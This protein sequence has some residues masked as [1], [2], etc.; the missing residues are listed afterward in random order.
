MIRPFP[1]DRALL[2]KVQQV[3]DR[4]FPTLL[5]R[6]LTA[7]AEHGPFGIGLLESA[8][9]SLPRTTCNTCGTCCNS[10]S[11]FPL[12][13]HRIV[14]DLM[15]RLPPDRLKEIF[16]AAFR[17]EDRI[18]EV[19][20]TDEKRLRCV[21]WHPETRLCLVHPVRPFACRLYGLRTSDGER[22]CAT[23]RELPGEPVP[24]LGL[25]EET[26]A[27]ILATSESLTVFPEKPS[28]AIFPF[29]FWL[30][31]AAFGTT[32]ALRLYREVLIPLSGPLIRY[33]NDLPDRPAAVVPPDPDEG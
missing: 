4:R 19:V 8:Q 15:S 23:V 13:Y 12:E 9:A 18:G 3:V 6:I 2:A 7:S 26:Q 22:E 20:G 5:T 11:I 16:R 29:E 27:R 17:L 28:S 31:R 32:D 21:F 30:F 10:I 14:R 24:D 1:L 33:W 25:I